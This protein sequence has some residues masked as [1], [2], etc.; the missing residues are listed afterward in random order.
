LVRKHLPVQTQ[1]YLAKFYA[2]AY[3]AN[4]FEEYQI[5]PKTPAALNG[6]TRSIEVKEVNSFAQLSHICR[7][8]VSKIKRLNPQYLQGAWPDGIGSIWVVLPEESARRYLAHFNRMPQRIDVLPEE[9]LHEGSAYLPVTEP[10]RILN[11]ML[12]DLGGRQ[13][14]KEQGQSTRRYYSKYFLRGEA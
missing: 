6:G 3:I 11:S 2:A 7:L 4:F 5:V 8:P 12:V 13:P 1:S 9:A 10:Y 14:A